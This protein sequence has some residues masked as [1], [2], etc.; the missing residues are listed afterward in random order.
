ML[1][2]NERPSLHHQ[3]G[4]TTAKLIGYGRP[5]WHMRWFVRLSP[6]VFLNLDQPQFPFH[7]NLCG[8]AL[9]LAQQSK[10]QVLRADMLIR[11]ALRFLQR[12]G[13]HSFGFVAQRKV[14][15][16]RNLLSNHGM[17]LDLLPDGLDR[18]AGAQESVRKGLVF[19]RIPRSRCSV[20]MSGAAES[21][22]APQAFVQRHDMQLIHHSRAHLH[23]ST[24][25]PQQLPHI[26]ILGVRHPD[27]RETIL[28]H[29]RFCNEIKRSCCARSSVMPALAK[30]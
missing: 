25:M 12:I 16:G 24:P 18:D 14:N 2:A 7:Q 11:Q 22:L 15:R 1:S 20:S 5:S 10:E 6:E 3:I 29:Q 8:E 13:Q 19:R 4:E 23:Q 17:G 26:A 9:F 28:E 27:P 30:N 21:F